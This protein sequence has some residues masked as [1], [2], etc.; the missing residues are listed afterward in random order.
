[1]YID[2]R[3]RDG[4]RTVPVLHKYRQEVLAEVVEADEALVD[5]AV[6]AAQRALEQRPLSPYRRF[7][8]LRR[9]ADLLSERREEFALTIAREAGKPLKYARVEVD[10]ALQTIS[11]S[12]EEAKRIH[13]EQVPV[14]AAP[15]GEGRL[16][17]TLRVPVGVVCAITPFNFPLNL[18]AHKV[19]P[20]LA[21]GNA[22]VLKP[23]TYTPLTSLMLAQLLQ[24]AGL[25][26]GYLNVVVGG[27]RTV[28]EALLRH[29]GIALYTFTGSPEVGERIKAATGLRRVVLELGNNSPNIVAQD[30]NLDQA[31]QLL[32]RFAYLYAGQF[33]IS[34]Q[35]I[36][37]EQPAYEPFLEKFVA[38]ARAMK[39][40]DPEDP[41]TDI[42]PLIS[43][44][45]ARR[46]E[47]WVEEAVHGGARRVLGGPRQ[48]VLYPATVLTDVRPE[49]KVVCQEV[50]GPVASV[51]A[52]SS[53]EE[54]LRQANDTE[55]GLQAGVFTRNLDRAMKAARTLRMGGVIVNDTSG[56]RVDLM[57][58]GG[59]RRS[60]IGRE[61]PRYAIEEMTDLRIVV[62]N[63]ADG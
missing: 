14:E 41:D 63:P 35:R 43:E 46:V 34:V 3:W 59:I 22:V 49:M 1:L 26:P 27:G 56:F 25:P 30:A 40:G 51:V 47:A 36:Y 50:F 32:A 54:A 33:C 24:E 19:A 44:D 11:L 62:L 21:A 4:P 28:G 37:V 2:G 6:Q 12:G 16:A 10:R 8:I 57:P 20:A 60:G 23:A 18:V 48:G 45:D 29:P 39:L 31:A 9:A 58:Y 17:F 15:G 53:F 52:C 61:G 38:A 42:G 5:E 55:Y 13:G 7:Q